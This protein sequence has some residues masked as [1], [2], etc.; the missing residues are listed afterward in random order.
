MV[1]LNILSFFLF[2]FYEELAANGQV[3]KTLHDASPS[4]PFPVLISPLPSC[5]A[6]RQ[7]QMLELQGGWKAPC[8]WLQSNTGDGPHI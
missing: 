3:L 2:I 7:Q 5:C 6:T 1:L 8:L 4:W